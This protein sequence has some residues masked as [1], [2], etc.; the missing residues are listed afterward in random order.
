VHLSP[1]APGGLPPNRAVSRVIEVHAYID[2]A[3]LERGIAFYCDGLGLTLKRRL[4]PSW[5]ELEG[6]NLPIFLLGNRKPTAKLGD[7]TIRRDFGRHW[8][9]VHLDF[10]VPDIDT[11]VARLMGFGATL[12]RPVQ[13]AEYG[14]MA[15]M[16]DPFGNGFDLI[17][18]SGSGYD[19]VSR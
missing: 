13:N 18:F 11:A 8:T 15:N 17:E 3:D 6:A 10:I 7:T 1:V 14:R 2:V 4:S 5:V 12:D 19:A 9:P 16:A